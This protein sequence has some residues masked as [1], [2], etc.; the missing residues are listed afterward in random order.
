VARYLL[1]RT[2]STLLVLVLAS[3]LI[4]SVIR[5]VPGDPVST[6]AGPD[7]SPAARAAVRAELGLD[8]PLVWQY[9]HWVRGML[10][11]DPGRSY[12]VGGNISS[13]VRE[14]LVN[15]LVLTLAALLIA[16]TLAVVASLGALLADRRWLDSLLAG[17]NTLAVALP[18]FVTGVLLVVVFAV[19]LP[20]LPAG[21]DPPDGFVARPDIAVQYLVMPA[22][23]LALPA[24]AAL[25]RFLTEGLRTQLAQPYVMTA[26]A[27]G[28]SRRRILL[29]QALPN[30]LPSA[31]TVLGVQVGTL[32]SGAVLVEAIFAW[33]GLGL[34]VEQA[35]SSRDY[36]LV[37]A[38]LL[39]SVVVFVLTQLV[40]DS[41]NAA[42]DPRIRTGAAS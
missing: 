33:P 13:L 35:I 8:Q 38:L 3:M 1:R 4:F 16:V 30:A 10:S 12:I 26:R 15:T 9:L 25:S 7:A 6:L 14:G 11:L 17:V 20:I 31:V 18:T 23:C 22:V 5:L 27:L 39:L 40:T 24:A 37:Q 41:V 19:V 36:P 28:I 29:T 42:L 34:L 21:G 2:L 32:L